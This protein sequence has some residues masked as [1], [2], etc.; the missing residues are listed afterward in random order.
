LDSP[1]VEIYFIVS[2]YIVSIVNGI[3]YYEKY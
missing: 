2:N 3:F 1:L